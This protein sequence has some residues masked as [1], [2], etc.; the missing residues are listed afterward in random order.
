M[1]SLNGLVD[2]K[3]INI[4]DV[5]MLDFASKMG[6]NKNLAGAIIV[7]FNKESIEILK[8]TKKSNLK[9]LVRATCQTYG[10]VCL[11]SRAL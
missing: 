7:F 9:A 2:T 10:T 5:C 3:P 1:P 6:K 8:I 11:T 4:T